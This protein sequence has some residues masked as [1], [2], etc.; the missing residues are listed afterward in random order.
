MV[1][2]LPSGI[3]R[4]R[5][6]R[7]DTD[8]T[9]PDLPIRQMLQAVNHCSAWIGKGTPGFSGNRVGVSIDYVA[10]KI[11]VKINSYSLF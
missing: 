7:Q 4:R 11:A 6:I 1:L 3:A 9:L 5:E 2:R 8:F 10:G